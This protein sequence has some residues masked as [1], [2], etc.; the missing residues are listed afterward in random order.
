MFRKIVSNLAFSPALVGQL[1]F[2]AQRLKKEEATRRVGLVFTALALV[3]QSFAVFSPPEAANAASPNDFVYGGVTS[4]T[5][6]ARHYDANTNN[7]KDLFAV[8]G[9][10]RT[11]ITASKTSEINSKGGYYSWGLNPHFSY[12]DGE[13]SYTVKTTSG[14]SRTF[15][16]RPLSLWDTGGNVAT[17]SSYT[18]LVGKATGPGTASGQWFALM[19]N[20]GNLVLKVIPPAPKCPT[21]T[22]GTYPNCTIPKC[23]NGTTGTYP[24]CIP[25]KCPTGTTGTPP[26]CVY[27]PVAACTKLT[28]TPM[29]TNNYRFDAQAT[30]EHGATISAYVYTI[31]R[32]GTMVETKTIASKLDTNTFVYNQSKQ[33]NYVVNLTIKTSLGDKTDSTNCVKT[34]NVTPPAVCPQ[35]PKLPKSSP[36]CQPCPGDPTLWIKDERCASKIIETKSAKNITQ[37]NIDAIGVAARASDKIV[38]TL[39]VHNVGKAA[40]DVVVTEQ[41]ADVMEYATLV[42]NGGGIYDANT[43]TLSW[44]KASVGAGQKLNRMFTVQL[45]GTIPAMGKGLSDKT[46]YDCKMDNT[47]GNTVSIAVTCPPQ[48]IIVEQTA[49]ELPHTGPRE[50]MIFAGTVFSIVAYFYARSRQVKKEVR[51]IR[52]DFNTGT[53]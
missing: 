50:N 1:G 18:V 31:K 37:G 32:D 38:Y 17:G 3:V 48:K 44:P 47:F 42:D 28:I 14:G 4:A 21:G 5:D 34:F 49:N 6:F 46:S 25:N 10:T 30:A 11:D 33:G 43:K 19:F 39:S 52:R 36:E 13:R 22:V 23:P 16:A 15:Y 41:L 9:I 24:N 40:S 12:A 35:N 2:Y 27:P 45:L 29:I 51:L 8:L 26:N 7:I 53:I 20:C